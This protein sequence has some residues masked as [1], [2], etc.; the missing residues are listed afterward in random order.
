MALGICISFPK[1]GSALN[2]YVTPIIANHFEESENLDDYENV[3]Y[4]LFIGFL[5]MVIGLGCSIGRF[6]FT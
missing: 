6:A 2:S 3:G 5:G 4:P 1:L